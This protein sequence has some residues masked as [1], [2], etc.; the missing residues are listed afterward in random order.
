PSPPPPPP[1]TKKQ[2]AP[3]PAATTHTDGPPKH[4][5][6]ARPEEADGE[7]VVAED[8]G[9]IDGFTDGGGPAVEEP[10]SVPPASPDEELPR[11]RRLTVK[12]P[13]FRSGCTSPE[14]PRE[15]RKALGA[16]TVRVDVELVVDEHGDVVDAK[17]RAGH[18][19]IPDA[20]LLA[21]ARDQRFEPAALPSGIAIPSPYVRRYLFRPHRL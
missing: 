10:P 15:V 16:A 9:P 5:P 17:V 21:C 1:P 2:G 13:V 18:P 20:L 6:D 3:R 4:I 12:K 7:L 19:A 11:S 14:L 8:T